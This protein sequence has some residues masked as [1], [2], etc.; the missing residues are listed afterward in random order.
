MKKIFWIFILPLFV[1]NCEDIIGVEDIS[2]KEV[3]ILAP[4]EASVLTNTTVNFSWNA[5][6]EAD[7]YRLQ[8]AT[9]DFENTTAIEEH[10]L[11]TAINFTK[12]LNSGSYQWRVRAENSNYQTPY[13]TQ[14]FSITESDAVDIS[15]EEVILLAPA[16]NL[17][18][19]TTDTIN[20]S[21]DMVLNAEEY[22]IQ[23]ATPDFASAI[24][25]IENEII[26]TTVFSVS[27]LEAQD[28]EWRVKAQNSDY[29]TS[30]TAQNF[31]VEE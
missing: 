11:V 25:I 5:V 20:F 13:T 31:T 30:Y 4:T 22:T 28:Y 1:F 8:I 10:T 14:S 3:S 21:W 12:A 17:I 24:E 29:E 16:D 9:P 23:I 6:E 18:F 19:L 7:S 2:N 26:S 15:N 27:N